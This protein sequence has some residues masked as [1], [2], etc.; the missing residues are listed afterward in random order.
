MAPGTQLLPVNIS[1]LKRH[2]PSSKY[3]SSFAPATFRSPAWHGGAL[4]GCPKDEPEENTPWKSPGD[5]VG[6]PRPCAL[7]VLAKWELRAPFGGG[8]GEGM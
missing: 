7:T 1:W 2:H 5:R 6:K 8:G 3:K 4:S